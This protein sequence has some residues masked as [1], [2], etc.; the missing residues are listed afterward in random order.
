LVKGQ[1]SVWP[2]LLPSVS[3]HQN[4]QK[5]CQ[6]SRAAAPAA[7]SDFYAGGKVWSLFFSSDSVSYVC[8]LNHIH[9][10][11]NFSQAQEKISKEV[12][13]FLDTY[14]ASSGVP[15]HLFLDRESRE[16]IIT[17]GTS[18]MMNKLGFNTNPGSFVQ[19]VLNDSLSG[20]FAKA[21]SINQQCLRFYATM[22]YSLGVDISP[23]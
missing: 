11:A 4:P 20:A 7:A 2:F 10:K 19:A 1:T 17:I 3:P 12:T 14:G 22:M 9:M 21:D 15:M 8:I 13:E 18:I 23:E 16:H 6:R 5:R